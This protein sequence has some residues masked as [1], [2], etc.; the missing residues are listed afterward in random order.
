MPSP[1]ADG[2]TVNPARAALI[3]QS[4][5]GQ[6]EPIRSDRDNRRDRGQR[7]Q[8]P[9][10]G[11]DRRGDYRHIDDRPP[12]AYHGRND[13]PREHHED[14]E[15]QPMHS[16]GRDRRDD[17]MAST[18]TGPR[19]GR[20][21][22]P[23]PVGGARDMFQ[24]PRPPRSSAQ[25]PNYGRL[26]QPSEPTPPSGPRSTYNTP[27]ND[28]PPL[29]RAGERSH[30]QSQPPT[31]TP[32]SGPGGGPPV[33]IHPSRLDNI[34]RMPPGPPLQTNMPNAPSGPRSSGRGPQNS[35]PSPVSRGPPTGPAG[36]ERGPRGSDRRN[37]LGAINSVLTQGGP[38]PEGRPNDRPGPQQNPPVRGRGGNRMNGEPPVGMA[39]DMPPPQHVSTPNSR[40]DGQ[41]VRVNRGEM[42]PGRVEGAPQEDGRLES[43][44]HRDNRRSERSGHDRSRSTDHNSERRPDERSSR[45]GP[46]RA[47]GEERSER[48]TRDKRNSERDGSSRRHSE[49]EGREP[50]ESRRERAPRD[51]NRTTS[52]RDDR[53]SRGGGSADDGRKRARDPTDQGQGHGDAKRRR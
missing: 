23:P 12:P 13:M 11:D 9:R 43:R 45:N 50:R 51:E 22:L 8:S 35:L 19:S 10:G 49:R 37:P 48:S 42:V 21:E 24:A 4:D 1:A 15:F 40:A 25:D 18:P 32:P 44:G 52:G 14:R 53:R 46:P 34:Q 2:P 5:L 7:G 41:N 6:N 26:N 30:P 36:N 47:E 20:N 27:N 16:G 28:G 38:P 29:G 17:P 33:G 39:N 31:P 3:N